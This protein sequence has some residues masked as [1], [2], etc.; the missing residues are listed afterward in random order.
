MCCYFPKRM[1]ECSMHI[2]N[3]LSSPSQWVQVYESPEERAAMNWS[4]VSMQISASTFGCQQLLLHIVEAFTYGRFHALPSEESSSL[5]AGNCPTFPACCTC[6]GLYA[7]KSMVSTV[8]VA[9][10]IKCPAIA[11][12]LWPTFVLQ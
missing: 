7:D 11:T 8:T 6:C 2:R 4:G 9:P 3:A 5:I 1:H 12:T 10:D